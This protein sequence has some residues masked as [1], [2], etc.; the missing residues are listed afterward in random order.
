[1][2]FIRAK[3][4]KGVFVSYANSLG[5]GVDIHHAARCLRHPELSDKVFSPGEPYAR[6]EKGAISL[7]EGYAAPK[8][9]NP[10]ER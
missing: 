1:M 4:G 7:C 5:G 10:W 2:E 9:A 3:G 8:W 6:Y